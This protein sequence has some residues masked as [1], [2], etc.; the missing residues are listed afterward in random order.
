MKIKGIGFDIDGTLYNNLFMY[1]CTIPSFLMHPFLVWHYGRSR[2]VI[3]KLR[4]IDNFRRVQA[5][6]VAESMNL[7]EPVVR[8]R[9]EKS[10]YENWEKSFRIIRPFRGLKNV[11]DNLREDGYILGV[12]S[13]F[14]VQNKLKY[15]GLEDWDCSFTSESTNYLKPHP[16]PFLELAKRMNLR[17]EEILYVGNSYSKDII[18]AS[19]VGMKTAFLSFGNKK[20]NIADFTFTDYRR[21]YDFIRTS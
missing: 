8:A 10:L 7:P 14:P 11:I 15:L 2:S 17:P 1:V 18:G 6:I 16:E 12:L 5:G 13:D 19:S 21:L 4:P 3:R 9:I 20:E